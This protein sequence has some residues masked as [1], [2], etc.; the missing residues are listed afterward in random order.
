LNFGNICRNFLGEILVFEKTMKTCSAK[1]NLCRN[2]ASDL[3]SKKSKEI[4]VH[5]V[6]SQDLSGDH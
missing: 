6:M 1:C 2:T 4:I 3:E 5:V